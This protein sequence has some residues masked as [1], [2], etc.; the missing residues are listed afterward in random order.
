VLVLALHLDLETEPPRAPPETINMHPIQ[1]VLALGLLPRCSGSNNTRTTGETRPR[2]ERRS[3]FSC[4]TMAFAALLLLG[5]LGC[6]GMT[7]RVITQA[8]R[9]GAALG[10]PPPQDF[11]VCATGTTYEHVDSDRDGRPDVVRVLRGDQEVC[12]ATDTNRD[13]KLDTWDQFKNGKLDRR[14]HDSDGNGRVDQVMEWTNPARPECAL[15]SADKNGDGKGD[16]GPKLDLC[17]AL[18]PA[19]SKPLLPLADPSKSNP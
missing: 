11:D 19:A 13:G 4:A 6:D 7:V 9:P 18:A 16:E 14:A 1:N 10:L 2:S 3:A 5:P 8:D 12:R 15:L 17:A